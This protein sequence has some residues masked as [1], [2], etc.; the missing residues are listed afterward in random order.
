MQDIIKIIIGI[1]M[2]MLGVPV[3]NYL[4]KFTKEELKSGQKWFKIIIILSL[5]GAIIGLIL[6]DDIL[7]FSFL[8]IATVTGR[9]LR[10]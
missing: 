7:L 6:G 9:S 4:A 5:I 2:I 10:K 8:F 3:G 1:L